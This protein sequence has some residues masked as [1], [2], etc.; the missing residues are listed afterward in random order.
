M[1]SSLSVRL[2]SQHIY[3]SIQSNEIVCINEWH[4]YTC[5]ISKDRSYV[6]SFKWR[7]STFESTLLRCVRVHWPAW[8]NRA[9]EIQF[10][11][12]VYLFI[13][14]CDNRIKIACV[15]LC[16]CVECYG[17]STR[18]H[19]RSYARNRQQPNKLRRH[20]RKEKKKTSQI[21][22]N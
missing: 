12:C 21:K 20:K 10:V 8:C 14:W 1:R 9:R 6:I 3:T 4:P 17:L 15:W 16:V 18:L 5:A 2:H 22:N 11:A 7:R 19:K 13:E